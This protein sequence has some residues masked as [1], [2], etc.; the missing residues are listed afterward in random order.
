[1][2][3]LCRIA[4]VLLAFGLTAVIGSGAAMAAPTV[5]RQDTASTRAF[6]ASAER[7]DVLEAKRVPAI[8]ALQDA[9][10][11]Q[12]SSGCPNALAAAPTLGSSAQR[13]GLL[14]F[15]TEAGAALEIDALQPVT[16]VT[17]RIAAVQER[18]RFSDPFV[19]FE[20]GFYASATPAYLALRPPDLC[21]D[22][23]ALAASDYT[24]LTPAGNTFWRDVATLLQPASVP[25]T[26]LLPRMRSYAPSAVAAALKRLPVLQRRFDKPLALSTHLTALLRSVFGTSSGLARR[27]A[28]GLRRS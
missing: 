7:Y 6:I 19:Q 20:V 1:V 22:A 8:N 18:L 9:Y 5:T 23:R 12:V 14:K 13:V 2:K 10:L 25:P 4:I 24:K 11:A 16:A 17:D 28:P 15:R 26:T 3:P 21:A 27:L